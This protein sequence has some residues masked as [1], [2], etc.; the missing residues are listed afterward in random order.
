VTVDNHEPMTIERAADLARRGFQ[1]IEIDVFRPDPE[2]DGY[3]KLMRRRSPNEVMRELRAVFGD[4][5]AG[6]EEYFHVY[7]A[8]NY[9]CAN[10]PPSAGGSRCTKY[11]DHTNSLTDVGKCQRHPQC[12][13]FR[14]RA[15][16]PWPD[17]SQLAVFALRGSSEGDYVHVE[18]FDS[19]GGRELILLAKTFAGRDVAWTF[20]RQLADLLG[21]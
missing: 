11:D 13:Q 12:K 1:P 9:E 7:S 10:C 2:R 5:P 14:S 17:W 18:S 16:A 20:A 19:R 21:V 15:D 4:S 8:L 6:G 3:L